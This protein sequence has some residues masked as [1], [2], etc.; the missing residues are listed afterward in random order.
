MIDW[1]WYWFYQF[2]IPVFN[3]LSIGEGL[4]AA[5][6][7]CDKREDIYLDGVGVTPVTQRDL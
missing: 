7:L 6:L 4:V 3:A 5:V 1:D 2:G